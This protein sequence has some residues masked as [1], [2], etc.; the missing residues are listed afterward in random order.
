MWT[1]TLDNSNPTVNALLTGQTL[2]DSFVVQSQDG[3]AQTVNVTI[4]GATDATIGFKINAVIPDPDTS[5]SLIGNI[6][7]LGSFVV[8]NSDGPGA[9]AWSV[10]AG[11][12]TGVNV[13][14]TTG[15]LSVLR[16]SNA[17]TGYTLNVQAAGAGIG[18]VADTYNVLIGSSTND[19]GGSL[20][21]EQQHRRRYQRQRQYPRQQWRG[22]SDRRHRE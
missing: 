21:L 20:R 10:L 15:V 4:N 18:N 2:A 17:V 8:L 9:P 19:S 12:T 7:N 13:N 14:P 1:Y 22:L 16:H 3:T 5:L 11:S 6:T